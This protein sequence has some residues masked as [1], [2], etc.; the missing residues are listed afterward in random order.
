M[1]DFP[2]VDSHVHLYD[3]ALIDYP[4]MQDI[5]ALN[6]AHYPDRFIAATGSVEV[7]AMVVVEVDAQMGRHRDE[8]HFIARLAATEPRIRGFVAALPL[9]QNTPIDA[10]LERLASLPLVRGIRTLIEPHQAQPG[11]AL[12]ASLI[13][14]LRKLPTYDLSFDLCLRHPQLGDVISLVRQCPQVRFVLDHIAKPGIREGLS[15]PWRSQLRELANEPNVWCKLSGV[16]TE[17]D[18]AHWTESQVRPYIDHA[19]D[20][21]GFGRLMFGSDWPVA[22]LAT[23]YE[24]WVEMVDRLT[25][26]ASAHERRQLYRDNVIHC[27]RLGSVPGAGPELARTIS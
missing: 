20:C 1:P 2:I 9:H 5:P 16:V 26:G 14:N 18:H 11:W 17:A 7:E 12:Q 21:F 25:V 10:E 15:E 6:L 4:W 3:P 22:E 8:A 13:A 24:Q 27:Y 19:I 23:T